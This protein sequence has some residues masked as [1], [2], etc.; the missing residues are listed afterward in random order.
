[1]RRLAR[2]LHRFLM[3]LVGGQI[4]LWA[5]SGL[6]MVWFDIHYIHGDH[7]VKGPPVLSSSSRL[8]ISF[9]DALSRFPEATSIILETLRGEPVYRLMHAGETVLISGLSGDIIE[10][11]SDKRAAAIAISRLNQPYEVDSVTLL[12]E[13]EE[14]SPVGQ[15]GRPLWRVEF[16]G[17][18]APT[19]Y[20]S[21]DTGTVEYIRHAPWQVFDW[22]WRLHIMDYQEG[23]DVS[24]TL[25]VS[26]TI[27]G[28]LAALAG[29]LLL[30]YSFSSS[31]K[32][33]D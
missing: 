6:Y 1:M 31:R 18:L 20:V 10:P 33:A 7:F 32:A 8:E 29:L 23:E 25:L 15:R 12:G 28:L 14:D 5:M 2:R 22:L 3:L 13:N 9:K 21:Q 26:M 16:K 30:P 11:L 19:F 27:I 4:F 24:N 17:A